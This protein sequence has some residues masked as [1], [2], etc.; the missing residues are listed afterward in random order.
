MVKWVEIAEAQNEDYDAIDIVYG[1]ENSKRVE[2]QSTDK[3]VFVKGDAAK[4]EQGDIFQYSTNAQGEV[5]RITLLFDRDT[6]GTEFTRTVG[7][8]LTLVYGRVTKKFA[9]SVNVSVNGTVQNYSTEGATVYEYNSQRKTGNVAVV[10]AGD[11]EV[12]EEGNE[13]RVFI[14]IFED[15][16]SEIVIVR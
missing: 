6:V 7:T 15:R 4:L 16:V 10:T 13:V 14:K 3:N 12:F 2:L 5:D 8:D 1:L 11:I 9:D